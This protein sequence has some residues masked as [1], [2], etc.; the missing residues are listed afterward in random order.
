MAMDKVKII[1]VAAVA[2]I[3]V[4]LAFS[5]YWTMIGIIVI[6]FFECLYFLLASPESENIRKGVEEMIE[7][8]RW[9]IATHIVCALVMFIYAELTDKLGAGGYIE[10]WDNGDLPPREV[11]IPQRVWQYLA[12]IVMFRVMLQFIF[13]ARIRRRLEKR[14]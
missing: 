3:L 7:Q 1:L 2:G 10:Y 13:E 12:Y 14:K 8:S 11:L 4:Q 9:S 6:M 5:I